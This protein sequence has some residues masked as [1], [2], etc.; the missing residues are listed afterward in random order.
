MEKKAGKLTGIREITFPFIN[1]T[2]LLHNMQKTE[3]G[4]KNK[5]K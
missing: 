1:C 4:K 3:Y 5:W 2:E